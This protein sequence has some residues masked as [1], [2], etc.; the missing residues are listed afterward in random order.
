MPGTVTVGCKLPNG[1]ILRLFVMHE[2]DQAIQGGGWRKVKE[3]RNV[4]E[5]V[6]INGNSAPHGKDL[7]DQ[8]G[9]H[10]TSYSQFATTPNVDADFWDQWF[11]QNK[12]SDLVR[13][14]LI[15]AHAKAA[16]VKAEAREKEPL[17]SGLERLDGADDKRAEN[18]R[19]RRPGGAISAISKDDGSV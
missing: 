14:G 12:Q 15:F 6:F 7:L 5:K 3:A 4:G 17:K 11:E 19:Q 13:N 10:I 1:L 8:F 16:D 9:E 18:H 2:E